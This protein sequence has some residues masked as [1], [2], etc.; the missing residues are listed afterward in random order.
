MKIRLMHLLTSFEIGGAEAVALNLA[1]SMD[2]DAFHPMA[3]SLSGP[4]PMEERF[5]AHDIETASLTRAKTC[6]GKDLGLPLRLAGL[7][8]RMRVDILHC[9]NRFPTLCG[10]TAGWIAGLKAVVSTRHSISMKRKPGQSWLQERAVAP[11]VAQYIAVSENVLERAVATGRMK[12]GKAGVIYNGVD[13]D[14]YHPAPT[15]EQPSAGAVTVGSVAR[16]SE[17]KCLS[18]LIEAIGQLARAGANLKLHLVGDG[19]MRKE[20]EEQT[21]AAGL[22]DRVRLLGAREDVPDLLRTFDIFVLSSRHEGLPLT[23]I[24]AMATG[25]PVVATRVGSLHELIEDG[26][27]GLLVPPQDPAALSEAIRRLVLDADFRTRMG[28]E[29]RAMAEERFSLPVAAR[30][31]EALYLRLLG[32]TTTAP[33]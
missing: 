5:R 3:C 2:R 12:R 7:L 19:P 14:V 26:R 1:R 18:D 11:L 9:H 31:H 29:G 10:A 24:E 28:R 20:L 23:V 22:D 25:L 6:F 27:N 4:G 30:E 8:R 17:E 32:K 15:D 13:T 33:S 16:L 21:L